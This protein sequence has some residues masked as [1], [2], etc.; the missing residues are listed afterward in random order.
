M[1]YDPTKQ[2]P[3][4]MIQTLQDFFQR[5]YTVLLIVFFLV[6]GGYLL[7]TEFW[8]FGTA[9]FYIS[10]KN[11]LIKIEKSGEIICSEKKCSH[12]LIPGTYK[13]SVEKENFDPFFGEM[14]IKMQ[15]ISEQKIVLQRTST[16]LSKEK[17]SEK[18][19]KKT[20]AKTF[21]QEGEEKF[22]ENSGFSFENDTLKYKNTEI[23]GR[24]PENSQKILVSSDEVGRGYWIIS[25][26]KI[27]L[28]SPKTQSV[29]THILTKN[30][31]IRRLHTTQNKNIGNKISGFLPLQDGS[32]I[33]EISGN[34]FWKPFQKP[35]E[36]LRFSPLSLSAICKSGESDFIFIENSGGTI[37]VKKY[38]TVSKTSSSWGI[39]ENFPINDF[40]SIQCF[41][42]T[43]AVIFFEKNESITLERN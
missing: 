6:S 34:F 43:K 13:F 30:S 28:F 22:P 8:Y 37:S 41:G 11:T 7:I 38:S 2:S 35:Q 12:E 33:T 39:L 36:K 10:E 18:Y 31:G 25:P 42:N 40:H 14:E 23:L 27:L 32:F 20:F 1:Q 15:E 26:Q 5:H 9:Q 16:Q 19:Q 17:E 24:I 3:P 29:S 4:P 21:L